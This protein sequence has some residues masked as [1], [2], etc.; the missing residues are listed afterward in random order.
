MRLKTVIFCRVVAWAIAFQLP[1]SLYAYS[2]DTNLLNPQMVVQ[3]A[4]QQL[5]IPTLARKY[6]DLEALKDDLEFIT[7]PEAK[8][9][10]STY[11]SEEELHSALKVLYSQI[12]TKRYD[13][14]EQV[15]L[16]PKRRFRYGSPSLCSDNS[17]IKYPA[18]RFSNL[19]HDDDFIAYLDKEFFRQ[20][21]QKDID[22][23]EIYLIDKIAL[24]KKYFYSFVN[25]YLSEKVQ[26]RRNH[27][28]TV[29]A[30]DT[31]DTSVTIKKVDDTEVIIS[32]NDFDKLIDELLDR[33][34]DKYLSLKFKD[35][36]EPSNYN[37]FIH[38]ESDAIVD[39]WLKKQ[40]LLLKRNISSIIIK[41]ID[42]IGKELIERPL[43][44]IFIKTSDYQKLTENINQQ[45]QADKLWRAYDETQLYSLIDSLKIKVSDNKDLPIKEFLS[46]RNLD[47][48]KDIYTG[49]SRELDGRSTELDHILHDNDFQDSL[50]QKL[51]VAY[52]FFKCPSQDV[53]LCSINDPQPA[54]YSFLFT[55]YGYDTSKAANSGIQ[56]TFPFYMTLASEAT[57]ANYKNYTDTVSNYVQAKSAQIA[58]L[59]PEDFNKYLLIV[60]DD[61]FY[62]KEPAIW[63]PWYKQ[64]FTFPEARKKMRDA[65]K[66][67][68]TERRKKL[69]EGPGFNSSV[70]QD[71]QEAALDSFLFYSQSVRARAEIEK[72]APIVGTFIGTAAA[73]ALGNPV[74]SLKSGADLL[75][76]A[77]D[78]LSNFSKYLGSEK[79]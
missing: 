10:V 9:L 62:F 58:S 64:P 51:L 25:S 23:Y 8:E 73:A 79:K 75:K 52:D 29:I 37:K 57:L 44:H 53:A 67:A 4:N 59:K 60:Y 43:N 55:F 61:L 35:R 18:D 76:V 28:E 21:Y 54:T 27:F 15:L 31:D 19:V 78:A 39:S 46:Q 3:Q 26:Q 32:K 24:D 65:A 20:K 11:K 5:D 72:D 13:K 17:C 66:A 16:D 1:L 7:S 45:V 6:S 71:S 56:V 12:L 36:L 69:L 68:Q 22:E 14:I 38:N 34:D 49:A 50:N 41:K 77:T 30:S 70:F 63:I 42:L 33:Y 74:P 40:D 47:V 48:Q 2:E